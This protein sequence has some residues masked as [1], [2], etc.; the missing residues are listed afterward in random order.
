M[1]TIKIRSHQV[2]L[3]FRDGDFQG[4]LSEGR[5]RL[6]DPL[7]KV[8]VDVVSMRDARQLV[9][10]RLDVIV[11]SGALADRAVV[12]DLKDHQRRQITRFSDHD[13]AWPAMGPG[14]KGQGEIVF[15]VGAEL[16]LDQPGYMMGVRD[17]DTGGNITYATFGLLG[18]PHG[19]V[20]LHVTAAVPMV[21]R[22]DGNHVEGLAITAGLVY[23]I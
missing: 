3:H 6:F 9:H 10:E 16:R 4:L 5:H 17:P 7:C 19:K 20:L 22:L 21:Q 2:G 1:K 15:Q 11:K 8:H 23:E 12:L 18:M 13:I 14:N